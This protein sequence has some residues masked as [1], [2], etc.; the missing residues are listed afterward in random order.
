L[1]GDERTAADRGDCKLEPDSALVLVILVHVPAGDSSSSSLGDAVPVT[2]AFP[3]VEVGLAAAST[4]SF[5]GAGAARVV[6]DA[7]ALP[8]LPFSRAPAYVGASHPRA[9][10]PKPS[11][12]RIRSFADHAGT[13]TTISANHLDTIAES[14][15]TI[16]R[17]REQPQNGNPERQPLP[18]SSQRLSRLT[19]HGMYGMFSCV[20]LRNGDDRRAC[21]EMCSFRLAS[22]GS[23]SRQR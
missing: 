1:A 7:D 3:F 2:A 4:L 23:S 13:T 9:V 12:V 19:V 5:D 22:S 6:V 11:L 20:Q 17:M 16:S 21:Q 18:T 10:Q 14:V 8:V 15:Q